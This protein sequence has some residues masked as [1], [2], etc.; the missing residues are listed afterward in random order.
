MRHLRTSFRPEGRSHVPSCTVTECKVQQVG[1]K[2]GPRLGPDLNSLSLSVSASLPQILGGIEHR[3]PG[4]GDG[5][6]RV[7][8][9]LLQVTATDR[10]D[11]PTGLVHPQPVGQG[12]VAQIDG[13]LLALL[14]IDRVSL[15]RTHG[16]D[17]FGLPND[18][19]GTR[20]PV[21]TQPLI[22]I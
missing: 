20:R 4:L 21:N 9:A 18:N 11:Q 15:H 2:K 6:E 19:H 5:V 14:Q 7:G 10:V 17:P 8:V 12:R 3:V 13:L 1:N 22:N 16:S